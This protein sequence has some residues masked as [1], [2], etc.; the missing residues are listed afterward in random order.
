[1]TAVINNIQ[2][3]FKKTI[4]PSPPL[5][6]WDLV[7]ELEDSLNLIEDLDKIGENFLGRIKEILPVEQLILLLYDQD[8]GKF[9]VN[10]QFGYS[11]E[12]LKNVFFPQNESLIKWLKINKTYVYFKKSP[13]VFAY[14]SE[15]EQMI[16]NSIGVELCF[17]LVSMNRL[18]GIIFIGAKQDETGYTDQELSLIYSLTPQTGIALENA[19]LYKEQRERFRRMSRADK[20]ATIG[21]LAAGAAHEIRNPLTAIKSTLQYLTGKIEGKKENTLLKN[22]LSETE[23]IDE[24]LSALLSFSRPSEIKRESEDLIKIINECLEL[25]SFQAR[26]MKVEITRIYPKDPVIFTFDKSQLKQLFLNLFLNSIQSMR[27]GGELKIEI[28]KVP[29]GKI[30]IAIS[31]AGEGIPE[32]YL[33]KIFDP[34]FTTKKGGTG[35][36]LS[37]C[38]GIIQSHKGEIEIKNNSGQGTTAFIRL[39]AN[40]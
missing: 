5:Y 24:I 34:F 38:Y 1:M 7:K 36:G 13:G 33:D 22:A 23:R 3:I 10:N 29:E 30:L 12:D 28:Q 26:K 35:L 20:L 8:T 17:P 2:R 27:D 15:R 14:L 39:P 16:L 37:I 31:D 6:P 4:R 19:V 9:R 11:L 32:E 25:I 18:I 40:I 21:E